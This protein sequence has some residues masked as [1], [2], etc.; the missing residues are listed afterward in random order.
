M[1]KFLAAVLLIGAGFGCA[2]DAKPDAAGGPPKLSEVE[3]KVLNQA[4]FELQCDKAQLQ[5]SKLSL[6]GD[7]M[8]VKNETFGVR[9][10]GKQATYKTSCGW[11]QCNVF[12]MAQVQSVTPQ[13]M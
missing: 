9:G 6:D 7:M 1:K 2:K 11:G 8:G 13:R 12:N 5:M 3:E 4:A 10:C